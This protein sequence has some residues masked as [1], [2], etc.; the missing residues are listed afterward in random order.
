MTDIK[1]TRDPKFNITYNFND[2]KNLV[3]SDGSTLGSLSSDTAI[4]I[5]PSLDASVTQNK[6]MI[7]YT[8]NNIKKEITATI[9]KISIMRDVTKNEIGLYA[10]VLHGS[11]LTKV[12]YNV[13]LIIPFKSALSNNS[14][15]NS[16]AIEKIVSSASKQIYEGVANTV[17]SESLSLNDLIEDNVEYI[18]SLEPKFK[19]TVSA[20]TLIIYKKSVGVITNNYTEYL[21]QFNNGAF[22]NITDFTNFMTNTLNP[23]LKRNT[24]T[25]EIM[26]DCAP[27]E[28]TPSGQ[29][30]ENVMFTKM[31]D[32]YG[33]TGKSTNETIV[34]SFFLVLFVGL[35]IFIIYMAAKSW[36]SYFLNDSDI[37][38]T[39]AS[40]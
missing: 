34:A 39:P 3:F 23:L 14:T 5:S 16:M 32:I 19:T 36:S 21:R 15:H 11:V 22:N 1:S 38:S 24:V 13:Y 7:S 29:Q 20:N 9:N 8:D 12:N 35:S 27:I 10:I 25:S 28:I 37:P 30:E 4:S 31:D 2:I 33:K 18:Y 40:V 6:I 17:L 26:I